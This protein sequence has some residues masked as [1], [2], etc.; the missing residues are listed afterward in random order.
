MVFAVDKFRSY[1]LGSKIIIYTDHSTIRHLLAKKDAK[2]R[3][4]R[5][6]LSLQKFDLEIKDKKGSENLVA[7]HLSRLRKEEENAPKPIRDNFLDELLLALHYTTTLW[8]ADIANYLVR[9]VI[10]EGLS[11]P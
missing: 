10:P 8:Y 5:W 7:D 1:L 11:H 2:P 4:M 3:L 9:G 6:V